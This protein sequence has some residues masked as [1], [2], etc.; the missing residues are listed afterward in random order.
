MGPSMTRSLLAALLCAFAAGCGPSGDGGGKEGGKWG[1]KAGAPS[2]AVPVKT[3]KLG[4][5]PIALRLLTPGGE[6][7]RPPG[8]APPLPPRDACPSP[9][10]RR[11]GAVGRR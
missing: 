5:G 9:K 10:G 2:E 1:K 6:L 11:R 3:E 4:R 8:S 7:R